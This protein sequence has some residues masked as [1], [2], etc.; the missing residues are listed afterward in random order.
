MQSNSNVNAMYSYKHDQCRLLMQMLIKNRSPHHQII[1]KHQLNKPSNGYTHTDQHSLNPTQDH[2]HH[3]KPKNNICQN[4]LKKKN[5]DHRIT[6]QI[7]NP[8]GEGNPFQSKKSKPKP[9]KKNLNSRE[10]EKTNR[11]HQSREA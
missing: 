3:T 1:S 2:K 6:F 10:K 9:T 11:C 4:L 8:V 7:K 5:L